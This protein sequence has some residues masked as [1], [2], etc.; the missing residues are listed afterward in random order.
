MF[1]VVTDPMGS[2][3]PLWSVVSG[4]LCIISNQWSCLTDRTNLKKIQSH[5]NECDGI[6]NHRISIVCSAD[7]QAQ[8]KEN[9]NALHHCICE[10]N[11]WRQV[12][13]PHKGDINAENVSICWHQHEY[14]Q[15]Y[16][17]AVF[18]CGSV[19]IYLTHIIQ[20]YNLHTLWVSMWLLKLSS[21]YYK[22]IQ[23]NIIQNIFYGKYCICMA[24][25]RS[26]D[27]QI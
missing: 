11:H 12:D 14:V 10:G 5:Y 18:N 21:Q 22:V 1:Q 25:C 23:H 8:I 9:I 16:Q 3:Q 20:Y 13:S 7:V 2:H 26:S 6:S 19:Q 4:E 17:F 15:C 27:V 24:I